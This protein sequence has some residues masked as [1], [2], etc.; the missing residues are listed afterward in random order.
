MEIEKLLQML[1][2]TDDPEIRERIAEEFPADPELNGVFRKSYEKYRMAVGQEQ[3]Q[4]KH[5][6][7]MT[8]FIGIAACMVLVVGAY[9]AMRIPQDRLPSV[10]Q[11]TTTEVVTPSEAPEMSTDAPHSDGTQT[12]DSP[13]VH[14]TEPPATSMQTSHTDPTEPSVTTGISHQQGTVHETEAS[15]QTGTALGTEITQTE[16][17][18]TGGTSDETA[19]PT[20]DPTE[21]TVDTTEATVHPTEATSEPME[22][23]PTEPTARPT[24]SEVLESTEAWIPTTSEVLESTEG[25]IPTTT[26]V[27][28]TEDMETTSIPQ[29]TTGATIAETTTTTTTETTTTATAA[30]TTVTTT[31]TVSAAVRKEEW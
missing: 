24:E 27:L 13:T 7:R 2:E 9:L 28:M 29:T 1:Q 15:M 22:E 6:F 23:M 14:V 11:E 12:T 5:F 10:K 4:A 21:P 17:M 19:V 30:E 26:D 18:T 20:V 31:T 16:P 25:W 3:K 8:H